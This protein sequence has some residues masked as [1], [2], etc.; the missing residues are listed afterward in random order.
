MSSLHITDLASQA[1]QLSDEHADSA[2][3]EALHGIL[4][5]ATR[6]VVTSLVHDNRHPI[7]SKAC[8]AA[9]SCTVKSICERR[10]VLV[11]RPAASSGVDGGALYVREQHARGTVGCQPSAHR[12]ASKTPEAATLASAAL[13]RSR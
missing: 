11:G 3:N 4:R 13:E 7:V 1:R 10:R 12:R 5:R 9:R 6:R 2:E 8:A